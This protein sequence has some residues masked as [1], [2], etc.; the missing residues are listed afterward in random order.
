MYTNA[1]SAATL[2]AAPTQSRATAG[3]ARPAATSPSG[4]GVTT[5]TC[6]LAARAGGLR[7]SAATRNEEGPRA[8]GEPQTRAR[9]PAPPRRTHRDALPL[10]AAQQR[11]PRRRR[12]VRDHHQGA[13]AAQ[14]GVQVAQRRARVGLACAAAAA[15]DAVERPLAGAGGG[16]GEGIRGRARSG[17][18]PARCAPTLAPCSPR[19]A[20]AGRRVGRRRACAQR[21]S[22]TATGGPR[23]GR[24]R[25]PHGGGG[26][27]R[28]LSII[29]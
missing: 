1:A 9:P 22:A 8:A 18:R 3:A 21:P 16:A 17:R 23:E 14:R 27:G 2:S 24:P 7:L 12:R 28:T 5:L 19:S 26:G 15:Q 25:A 6:R 11:Q 10:A 13:R 29:A 20:R 4:G